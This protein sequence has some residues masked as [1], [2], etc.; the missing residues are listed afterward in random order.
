MI[1]SEYARNLLEPE[2]SHY[3]DKVSIIGFDPYKISNNL[4]F[5]P[6][7]SYPD[8]VNYLDIQTSWINLEAAKAYKSL[9]SYNYFISGF[10]TSFRLALET[11]LKPNHALL[12][13]DVSFKKFVLISFQGLRTLLTTGSC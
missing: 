12:F 13:A 3:L 9:E 8:I 11:L 7:I 2:K 10:V 4:S 6:Q 5:L 1:L